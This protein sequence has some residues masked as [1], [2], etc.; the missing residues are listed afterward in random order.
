M[1]MG[2]AIEIGTVAEA[3]KVSLVNPG[4]ACPAAAKIFLLPPNCPCWTG[5]PPNLP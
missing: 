1:C 5:P 4:S 2:D 3:K